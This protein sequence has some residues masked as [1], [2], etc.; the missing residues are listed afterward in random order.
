MNYVL[1]FQDFAI[2]ISF[3][4]AFILILS[5]ITLTT[6]RISKLNGIY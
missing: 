6:G 5:R 4:L 3:T 1:T 2:A